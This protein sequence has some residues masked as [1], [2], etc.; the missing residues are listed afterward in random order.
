MDNIAYFRPAK[1]KEKTS[2]TRII[3]Q[4]QNCRSVLVSAHNTPDGN[5]VGA[6]LALGRAL[7]SMH[8]LVFMYNEKPVPSNFH[9]LPSIRDVSCELDP[10]RVFDTAVLLNCPDPHAKA[11][12]SVRRQNGPTVIN[13]DHHLSNTG[14]GD[15]QLI[16]HRACG[17]SEI[18]YRIIRK[19]PVVLDHQIA[20]AIYTG[21]LNDTGSFCLKSTNRAAFGICAEMIGLGVHADRVAQH[22]TA[23]YSIGQIKLLNQAIDSLE[24]SKNGKVSVMTLTREMFQETG[25]HP[26]NTAD[27][28]DHAYRL[29]GVKLAVLIKETALGWADSVQPRSCF[30]VSLKS[31]GDV[32]AAQIAETYGGSGHASAAGFFTTTTLNDLKARILKISESITDDH[33]EGRRDTL[34]I[35]SFVDD[36]PRP[37]L[38]MAST[39]QPTG[40]CC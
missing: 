4:M 18:V 10:N 20:T 14:F 23:T 39:G 35:N 37:A 19:L 24:I 34:N 33:L 5:A 7:K 8:K 17:A 16:D 30:H 28:I 29:E 2:L 6:L 40:A 31:G 36:L 27:I 15:L 38:S 21:I 32:N 3:E 11:M 12:A 9:F 25:N 26:G 13:I 1:Q 22:L